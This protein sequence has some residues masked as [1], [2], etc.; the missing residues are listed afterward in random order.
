MYLTAGNLLVRPDVGLLFIDFENPNRLRVN[1]RALV[2][3]HDPLLVEYHEAQLV[4]RIEVQEIFV[5]CPRYVHQATRAERSPFVPTRGCE[6]P[7][8]EWKRRDLVRDA[9]PAR[10]RARIESEKS[11]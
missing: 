5:N 7:I 11:E 8:P 4:V 6:T 9:L 3:L 2:D 10:D 1:G